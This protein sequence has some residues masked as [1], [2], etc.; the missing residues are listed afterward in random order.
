MNVRIK[1]QPLDVS[2]TAQAQAKV[3][4]SAFQALSPAAYIMEVP[5]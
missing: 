1:N 2:P 4:W 3:F 5:K